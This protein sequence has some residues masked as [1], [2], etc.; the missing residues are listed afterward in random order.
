MGTET[1]EERDGAPSPGLRGHHL[2]RIFGFEVKLNLTWLL[3]ALLITWTLAAG[4]FPADY[5]DLP[6]Q[7]YWW[8]G[9]AGAVGIFFSIVFHE[10]SHSLIAR[11]FGLPIKGITLFIFGGVAEMQEEPAGA[12]TEFLMAAAGPLASILLS[13]VFFQIERLAEA[14]QWSAALLGVIHYLA[15]INLVLAV[16][17]LL[18]A[19]PLD[20]GRM[21]RAALWQWR[22]D[23]HS[24]TAIAS[25]IGA[26]FGVG[27]MILGGL[28]FVQGVFIS[29]MWWFLIGTF[30]RAAAMN[31]FQQLQIR[32]MLSHQPVSRF[33]NDEPVTVSPRITVE[34]LL[35]EYVQ[36]HHYSLYP[37]VEGERLVGCVTLDAI[38]NTP[39]EQRATK[40]V[41]ELT[42]P[43][44]AA[45]TV[46]PDSDAVKLVTEMAGPD[47]NTLYMVVENGRLVGV[48]SLK[49]FRELIAMKLKLR[50]TEG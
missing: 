21:L 5:P 11:R 43:C 37:V 40:T 2:F 12:K 41:S 19:F 38:R 42:S 29:G 14:Q 23:L 36:Q 30:L 20:G 50:S 4:F 3:L 25:R 39:E 33:M 18:P 46:S 7:T 48:I 26:G 31:S 24:A 34:S 13:F 27:M 9:V 22:K 15:V 16:F 6:A 49:D 8:M 17:N 28:A 35:Q 47:A 45:N 1:P 44:S 10:L 32:E